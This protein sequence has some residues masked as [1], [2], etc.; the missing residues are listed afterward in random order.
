MSERTLRGAAV[1]LCPKLADVDA[2]LDRSRKLILDA[3]AAG[4]Q[5]VVLPE[6][7]TTG[8]TFDDRMLDGH[9]PLE[10]EPMQ[11]LK[12]LASRAGG[13]VAG[14]F[15]AERGGHVYNTFVLALSDGTVATHDKDFPSGPIEHAYY[16]GGEDAEFAAVLR[17]H[18][19]AAGDEPIPSRN[20]NNTNGVFSLPS[21]NIGAAVCWE[22][23]RHRTVD[24]MLGKIDVVF[25]CSAWPN[26][27][28]DFA[29][30]GMSR[31]QVVDL[32]AVLLATLQNAPNR[33]VNILGIPVVHANLVGPVRAS[34]FFD[35]S[36]ELV[37]EFVG[38]SKIVDAHGRTLAV[39]SAS[40]GEGLVV[41]DVS[42]EKAPPNESLGDEFWLAELSPTLK[43][44]WYSGGARGRDYYLQTTHPYRN[45]S[46]DE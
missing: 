41:A 25:A 28:P 8:I 31:E 33:L 7:F 36:V 37:T 1:Q 17:E 14:S 26:I 11:L 30:P 42:L 22:M 34:K 6:L 44:L 20:D 4:A 13:G 43:D 46:R 18:G 40:E 19:I 12:E 32:N 15:L 23:I 2:N 3:L 38:E 39:R 45:R 10:G 29:L 16:A 35:D 24:R 27:D 21:I 5:W 9:R